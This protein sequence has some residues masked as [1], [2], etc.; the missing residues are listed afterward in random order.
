M[1]YSVPIIT[2]APERLAL[3]FTSMKRIVMKTD[4]ELQNDVLAELAWESSVNAAHIGV[5]VDQGVVTLSGHVDTYAEK[6]G[7]ER[8][9]KR[10]KGTRAVAIELDVKLK[11]AQKR[12]DSDIALSALNA[13]QW[14]STIPKDSIHIAVE[15]GMITLSGDVVW[16]YERDAA[17]AAVRNLAGVRGVINQIL[18]KPRVNVTAIKDDIAAALKRHAALD[19]QQIKISID[20]DTVTLSGNVE[21]WSEK[22]LAINAAWNSPG[23]RYVVDRLVMT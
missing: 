11:S 22:N 1:L 4:K 2:A 13:M 12:T 21:S 6:W 5:E 14:L 16:N 18:V 17:F 20:G 7:A 3:Q 10:V 23:V 19:A 15:N 8:A 9:A